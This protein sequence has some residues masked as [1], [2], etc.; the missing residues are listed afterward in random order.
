MTT[1]VY[2]HTNKQIAVDGRTTSGGVINTETAEKWVQD[3]DDFWFICG[4][5]SDEERL[6]NH[7]NAIEPEA[8]KWAIECAALLVRGSTVYL[9]TVTEEGEP[10]VSKIGY[11]DGIGSGGVFALTALDHGKSA[12][13]AVAYAATRDTGTGGK[14]MVMN[15]ETMEFI[16]GNC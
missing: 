16:D 5:V 1:I 14:I 9:C 10:S 11:S 8:P 13:E 3:G 7:I 2:D 6:I 4:S 15:V 12:H